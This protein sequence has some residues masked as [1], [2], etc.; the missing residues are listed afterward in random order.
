MDRPTVALWREIASL[1]VAGSLLASTLAPA[2]IV[3][4]APLPPTTRGLA[5]GLRSPDSVLS[6]GAP[7]STSVL[8]SPAGPGARVGM[9]PDP[10]RPAPFEPPV[11]SCAAAPATVRPARV[12]KSGP[13]DRKVVAL[14]FDDGWDPAN[15]LQIL[16]T[17]ERFHV[18]ATFFPVGRAVLAFP[19]VWQAVARARFPIGDHSFDHP[20]LQGLCFD[21]QLAELTRPQRIIREV[22]DIEP[23]G[24]MRPPYGS[25]DWSTRLAANAAGDAAVIL[26]DVDT[27]DWSGISRWAITK[28]ALS[29]DPGSIILMHTFVHATA[30]A[31]PRIIAVYRARGYRFV[32]IGQLLGL[33]GPVPYP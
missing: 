27:R 9:Q 15:T 14:T 10:T 6:V 1:L 2:V 5:A 12:V 19:S 20:H 29:G 23:F 8:T 18:N 7:G 21:V 32:T 28:A 30:A 24:V 31:L 3:S 13:R 4:A 17:L 33:G 11:P 25:Y 22:L 16:G 26:W